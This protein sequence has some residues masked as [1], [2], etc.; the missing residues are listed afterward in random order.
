MKENSLFMRRPSLMISA[1]IY[2]A[3]FILLFAGVIYYDRAESMLEAQRADIL[4]RTVEYAVECINDEL[5]RVRSVT[6]SMRTALRYTPMPVNARMTSQI[7]LELNEASRQMENIITSSTMIQ[8]AYMYSNEAK[9]AIFPNAVLDYEQIKRIYNNNGFSVEEIEKLHKTF[10]FGK[11]I[12]SENGR[13]M[14]YVVSVGKYASDEPMRQ[15]VILLKFNLLQYLIN[16]IDTALPHARYV[17]EDGLGN[18]LTEAQIGNVDDCTATYR[19]P[20]DSGYI[21]NVMIQETGLGEE[22]NQARRAYFASVLAGLLIVTAITVMTCKFSKIPINQ[23]TEYIRK[24]YHAVTENQGEGLN[25]LRVVVD[26]IL[27][28]Q[29]NTQNELAKLQQEKRW[30]DLAALFGQSS[31]KGSGWQGKNYVLMLFAPSV[32]DKDKLSHLMRSMMELEYE[33]AIL[34]LHSGLALMIGNKKKELQSQEYSLL[35]ERILSHLDESEFDS[36]KLAISSCH[37][38]M[39]EINVAYRE[40][41][42]A[43]D[44]LYMRT[45][46][47]ALSYEECDFQPGALKTDTEYLNRQQ[48]FN[49]LV[50][51][52]KYNDAAEYLQHLVPAVFGDDV[53]ARS[54]TGRMHLEMVKYQMISCMDYLYKGSE[55]ALEIRRDRIRE[56]LLC[57]SYS[58]VLDI[59]R[60]LLRDMVVPE[61][62]ANEQN[63]GDETLLNIKIYVRTHYADTQL[64]ITS[65]AD[66]F[67]MSPNNVSKLF[68]RKAGIGVLQYIH[69]IR[70]E[71]AC[72]LILNTDMNLTEISQ[73]VGYTNTLTF[74]RAFKARYHMSPSE[75]R[76][77]NENEQNR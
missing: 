51:Q 55:E 31:V 28:N 26:E 12:T 70:I 62:D 77:M 25:A 3:A 76:H 35:A 47:P 34:T 56:M 8:D 58:Q 10:T 59:M 32:S 6:A 74:S 11:F 36:L 66:Q 68:S 9:Y 17:L 45:D 29:A 69:R 5:E 63:G 52:G 2:L 22:V 48:H 24:N 71:N 4:T 54:E 18:A 40:A 75:W 19:Y 23:L 42:M 33:W 27:E 37:K 50:S 39:E 61:S 1:A 7:R 73:K 38:D 53:I 41:V 44:C 72:N 21:L 15:I 30:N 57:T 49:R 14:A 16:G 67:D 13:Q 43:R 64:S 65:I 60:D 46:V 20:L